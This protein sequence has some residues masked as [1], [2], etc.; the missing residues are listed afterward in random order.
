VLRPFLMPD[1][2]SPT[3]TQAADRGWLVVFNQHVDTYPIYID[4]PLAVWV[5]AKDQV[6]SI[7]GRRRPFIEQSVYPLR[8]AEE[9]WQLLTQGCSFG[10]NISAYVPR[11]PS[12]TTFEAHAV[13]LA[14]L[15]SHANASREIMQPYYV[16]RNED[17]QGLFVP[18]VAEPFVEW[19]D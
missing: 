13:E 16:F 5:N 7:Q 19:L 18:A 1:T 9:A 2:G 10:I 4:R 3:V 17:G 8:S 14:Y 6:T 11:L 12:G 15:V